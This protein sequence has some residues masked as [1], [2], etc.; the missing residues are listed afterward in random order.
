MKSNIAQILRYYAPTIEW[1]IQDSGRLVAII[2]DMEID[3]PFTSTCGR[4][5]VDP[6]EAY[7][8]DVAVAL[9]VHYHNNPT[10]RY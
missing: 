6:W 8:M 4:F 10:D 7:G 3:D 1:E 9:C 5:L 2:D